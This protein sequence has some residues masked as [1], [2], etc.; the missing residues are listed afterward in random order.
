MPIKPYRSLSEINRPRTRTEE[1]L[2][3]VRR[4]RLTQVQATSLAQKKSLRAFSNSRLEDI[5]MCPTWGVVHA[6][7]RYQTDARSMALEAGEL[8]HKVFAAVRLWQ[9]D[10][11]QKLPAHAAYNG[12]RIFGKGPWGKMWNRCVTHT[13]DR[14]SLMELCFAV[15]AGG[16]WKDLETDRTRTM[17]NMELSTIEYINERLE[18]MD[19]WPIY[20]EDETNPQSLVGIEQVFDVVLTY[21]DN[22]EIG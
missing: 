14:D 7:R 11:V 22:Y 17:T 19:N 12:G 13:D 6:Q 4:P 20:V 15:L 8:M 21:D 3:T 2:L 10:K 18:G 5:A 9:L 16:G 1:R